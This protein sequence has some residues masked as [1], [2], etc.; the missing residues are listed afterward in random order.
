MGLL[1]E[2]RALKQDTIS[3]ASS[4]VIKPDTSMFGNDAF[5]PLPPLD[6][7]VYEEDQHQTVKPAR[8]RPLVTNTRPVVET[9]N[10]SIPHNLPNQYNQYSQ[11]NQYNPLSQSSVPSKP[12]KKTRPAN[13]VYPS[14]ECNAATLTAER[15]ICSSNELA[16]ADRNLA[17]AFERK[18]KSTFFEIFRKQMEFEQE[19]WIENV[20]NI[21][22]DEAC[23]SEAY[24]KRMGVLAP[25]EQPH[26]TG[27]CP[28]PGH[29]QANDR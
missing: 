28:I 5:K 1:S 13:I 11:Y 20:R 26:K 24:R 7:P 10:V 2:K 21:C 12:T 14:F 17:E 23:L 3:D 6:E 15:L 16:T 9:G 4:P 22:T 27:I 8:K 25:P 19:D 18:K 29:C